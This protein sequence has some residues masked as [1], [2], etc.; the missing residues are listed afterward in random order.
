V[1]PENFV[2]T[3]DQQLKIKDFTLLRPIDE[4][5]RGTPVLEYLNT[6][7]CC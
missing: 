7:Y 3:E 1:E 5:V 6:A 2:V 4:A